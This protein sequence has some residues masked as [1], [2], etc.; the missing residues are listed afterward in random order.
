MPPLIV[1]AV[2][3]MQ[4]FGIFEIMRDF[5]I[6]LFALY[7]IFVGLKYFMQGGR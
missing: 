4:A 3:F 1:Y 2:Q 5:L 6:A 7:V